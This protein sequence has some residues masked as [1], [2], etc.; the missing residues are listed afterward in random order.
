MSQNSL[1]RQ[2]V[3]DNKRYAHWGD[4]PP[5]SKTPCFTF[6]EEYE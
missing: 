2:E 1:F 4:L 5:I 6:N 3:I